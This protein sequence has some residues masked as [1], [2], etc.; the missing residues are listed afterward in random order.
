MKALEKDRTRRYESANELA[1][2]VSGICDDEPVE[3]CPP[4]RAVPLSA[5][6]PAAKKGSVWIST[7]ALLLAL[8]AV[9]TSINGWPTLRRLQVQQAIDDAVTEVATIARMHRQAGNWNDQT[10]FSQAREQLQRAL[11][12]AE[13]G[14]VD[15]RLIRGFDNSL[16]NSMKNSETGNCW[17]PCS[18]LGS[19]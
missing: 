8:I 10:A 17:W 19:L 5:S 1:K 11:A 2:D 7:A 3:A 15:S 4:S 16:M 9:L 6:L 12:L 18:R 13:S 14:S